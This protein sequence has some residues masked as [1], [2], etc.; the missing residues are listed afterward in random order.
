[1]KYNVKSENKRNKK[2]MIDTYDF[3]VT[4]NLHIFYIAYTSDFDEYL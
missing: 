3:S 4:H 2:Y 1:M